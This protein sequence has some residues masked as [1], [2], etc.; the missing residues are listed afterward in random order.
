MMVFKRLIVLLVIFFITSCASTKPTINIA[1]QMPL[2][3][4]GD[5]IAQLKLAVAYDAGIG[6]ERNIQKAITWYE[7]SAEQGN[8]EA[9]NSLGGIYQA[10]DGVSQ[11]SKEAVK[12]FAKAAEQ[13]HPYAQN[14]LAIRY[15]S[16]QGVKKDIVKAL[17]WYEESASNGNI[18]A[19][20][21]LGQIY[22][23][24]ERVEKNYVEAYKW[25]ELA[26]FYTLGSK[27]MKLKWGVRKDLDDLTEKMN[28][29]HISEGKE[30][31]TD[32]DKK[33]RINK[34]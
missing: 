7:K 20:R 15:L 1:E 23:T 11:D 5:P 16:G 25:L 13:N 21:N 22:S 18:Y 30:R 12:W 28:P 2:A 10:G 33:N 8:A 34:K 4:S 32:W 27:N 26:R 19:F 6:I 9:Q 31:A 17:Y 3:K 24:G 29:S 14:S